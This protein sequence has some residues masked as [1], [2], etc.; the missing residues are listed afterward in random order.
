MKLIIAG[1]GTGGHFYPG[2]VIAKE[3]ELKGHEVVFAVKKNDISIDILKRNDIPFFELDMVPL[4]RS[5][6]PIRFLI[7]IYKFAKSLFLSLK[8]LKDYNP[9]A[10]MGMGSYVAFPIVIGAKIKKIKSFIHESNSIFGIGNRICG[11]FAKKVFLGLPV[12]NNP[13]KSKSILTGTPIRKSFEEK[14]DIEKIKEKL[15]IKNQK[16]IITI[17]GGSQGSKNI[18]EAAYYFVLKNKTEKTNYTIIQITGK[19]NFNET[20]KRYEEFELIDENL[21]LFEYYENMQEIYAISDL[22]ISRSGAST[23]SEL[24]KVKKPAILIPLPSSAQ[25][26]Q[27]ENARFLFEK[28]CALIIKDDEN[29]RH[30][31]IKNISFL[32]KGNRLSVMTKGYERI[33]IPSGQKTLDLILKEITD[34]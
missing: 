8:V 25:N 2:Y 31:L 29:L 16:T 27:Y 33:E 6:N 17:F 23:I 32:L 30:N 1:G 28:E 18:N 22:I 5:L 21:I 12:R 20:K 26:H 15:K 3:L 34:L 19:K 11:I 14:P 10:V 7:F 24:I 4:P 13:F 9:N